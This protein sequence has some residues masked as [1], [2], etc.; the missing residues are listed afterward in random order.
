MFTGETEGLVEWIIDDTR[1]FFNYNLR[2]SNFR[3]RDLIYECLVET[4]ELSTICFKPY[5]DFV[6][7]FIFMVS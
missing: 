3:D 2:A 7:Y 4:P 5:Q 6:F 1:F